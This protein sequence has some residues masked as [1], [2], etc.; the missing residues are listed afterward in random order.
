MMTVKDLADYFGY[1]RERW[2]DEKE[3]E[4]FADYREAF[5]KNLPQGAKF[6]SMTQSPFA[7]C[8]TFGGFQYKMKATAAAVT[9]SRKA[10]R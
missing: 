10:V 7:A 1:L 4:D 6:V 5:T 8:F 2:K 3:Y 9:I